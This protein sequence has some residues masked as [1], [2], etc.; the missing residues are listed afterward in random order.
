MALNI[1]DLFEHAVDVVPDNPALMVGDRRI[2][3]AELEPE[4]NR[5]AHHLAAQGVGRGTTS[6]STPRTASSTWS[7]CSP[8]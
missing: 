8:S 5:L 4:S 7:P 6:G 3:Y 2:T 1:A